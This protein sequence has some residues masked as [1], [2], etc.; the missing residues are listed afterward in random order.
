MAYLKDIPQR[1]NGRNDTCAARPAVQLMIL[2]IPIG[3]FCRRCGERKLAE[4]NKYG[5]VLP[6]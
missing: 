3:M 5:R 2:G 4:F 6:D 1:C